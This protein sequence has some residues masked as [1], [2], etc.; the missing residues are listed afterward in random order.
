[1]NG[2]LNIYHVELDGIDLGYDSY[3]DFITVAASEEE[4]RST[5]P[6]GSDGNWYHDDG[7]WIKF[8]DRHTL[9]V[10]LIGTAIAGNVL[11]GEVICASFHAE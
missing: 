11:K 1:M 5:H 8:S 7:D 10:T 9:L 3:S 6:S 4:A 2:L